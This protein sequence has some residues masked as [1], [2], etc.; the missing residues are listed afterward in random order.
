MDDDHI[1]VI[2]K[3]STPLRSPVPV[4]VFGRNNRG[5]VGVEA[6]RAAPDIDVGAAS[7]IGAESTA[8]EVEAP[9]LR[10]QSPDDG[11][12]PDRGPGYVGHATFK[13][14]LRF[15]HHC[16][17]DRVTAASYPAT[18]PSYSATRTPLT[19]GRAVG[20]LRNREDT[21]NAASGLPTQSS[22]PGRM[23]RWE[24]SV[25][26]GSSP[27]PSAMSRFAVHGALPAPYG[28]A[29][30]GAMPGFSGTGRD[31]DWDYGYTSGRG[32]NTGPGAGRNRMG[33]Q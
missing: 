16:T 15:N 32:A 11:C 33:W 27:P 31:D 3:P 12:C 21:S 20:V 18:R 4:G 24:K 10:P 5:R 23:N 29:S 13:D 28:N 19:Q 1:D 22:G 7:A 2:D 25:G 6:R 14:S 26:T 9:L 17:D 30:R 8:P